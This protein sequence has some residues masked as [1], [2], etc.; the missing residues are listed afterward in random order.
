MQV[1]WVCKVDDCP[2]DRPRPTHK[3]SG[4][5]TK[6][7]CFNSNQ[8]LPLCLNPCD[9][10]LTDSTIVSRLQWSRTGR[11]HLA[12]QENLLKRW[13]PHQLHHLDLLH[14]RLSLSMHP[15]DSPHLPRQIWK[16]RYPML[17]LRRYP[18]YWKSRTKFDF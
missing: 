11:H 10:W 9:G 5:G 3:I 14:C 6:P 8:D 13:H 12:L 1:Q 18:P 7:C 16:L 4:G 15:Y 2:W 17:M